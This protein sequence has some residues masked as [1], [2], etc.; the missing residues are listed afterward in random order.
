MA[1]FITLGSHALQP[2][3]EHLVNESIHFTFV[4]YVH[5]LNREVSLML[6]LLGFSRKLDS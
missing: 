1:E 5:V 6:R 4:V 2:G 3:V